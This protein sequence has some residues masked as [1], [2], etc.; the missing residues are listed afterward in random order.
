[1][2]EQ[3]GTLNAGLAEAMAGI[4]VVKAN[5]QERYEWDKFVGNARRYRDLFVR[6]ARSRPSICRC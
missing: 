2:R 1:L 3:F 4:E 6:R 5:V